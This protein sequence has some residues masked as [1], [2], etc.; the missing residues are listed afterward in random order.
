MFE[1]FEHEHVVAASRYD[2][3]D[4][5]IDGAAEAVA[6]LD[7]ANVDESARARESIRRTSDA[8]TGAIGLLAMI[9]AVLGGSLIGRRIARPLVELRNAAVAFGAGQLELTVAEKSADEVG[10]LASAFERMALAIR[11]QM[12]QLANAQKLEALGL[13]AGSVAHDFNNVLATVVTCSQLALEDLG[14]GHPVSNDLRDIADAARRGARLSQQL[15]HFGRPRAASPR[16]LSV[17]EAVDSIEPMLARLVGAGV[18]LHVTRDP[19]APLVCIDSTQLDQ[20]LMN[21][22]VNARDASPA[23]GVVEIRTSRTEL[24]SERCSSPGRSR[25]GLTSSWRSATRARA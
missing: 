17:N 24:R 21:L 18:G 7:R 3:Y 1:Q 13:V 22:V 15:L 10:E 8:L 20:V 12:T 23:G 16:V 4:Q 14:E 25:P 2:A 11:Q 5:A 19:G 6:S 9:G